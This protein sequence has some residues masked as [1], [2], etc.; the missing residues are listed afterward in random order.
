[1]KF[2]SFGSTA[3]AAK[4]TKDELEKFGVSLESLDY[5]KESTRKALKEIY[6]LAKGKNAA[7]AKEMRI[8][9][10]PDKPDGCVILFSS[11]KTQSA[12]F[13]TESF[14]ALCDLAAALFKMNLTAEKS[15]LFLLKNE[16]FLSVTAKPVVISVCGE[17]LKKDF[18]KPDFKS[19]KP[20]KENILEILGGGSSDL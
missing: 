7:F 8:D 9:V 5:S 18:S 1:M 3:V 19:T 13:K 2:E 6:L 20:V 11:P 14:D 10:F 15:T 16:F 12:V 17:F 4:I